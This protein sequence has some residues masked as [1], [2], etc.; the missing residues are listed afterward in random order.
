MNDQEEIDCSLEKLDRLKAQLS[1][2]DESIA[3]RGKIGYFPVGTALNSEPV[4]KRRK[5]SAVVVG[6]TI[7]LPLIARDR[8]AGSNTVFRSAL[9][10]IWSSDKAGQTLSRE[11]LACENG[12]SIL[13]SG[14]RL[15]QRDFLVMATVLQLV[16]EDLG[17]P[18]RTTA[19]QFLKSMGLNDGKSNYVSLIDSLTRLHEASVI[20]KHATGELALEGQLLTYETR[21]EKGIT[22]M[23]LS[24]NKGWASL[25]GV[26]SWTA[27]QQ[28]RLTRLG[29]KEFALWLAGVLVTHDGRRPIHID[30]LHL[31]SGL[32][33]DRRFFRRSVRGALVDCV[34]AGIIKMGQLTASDELVFAPNR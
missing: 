33:T 21:I 2:I 9:F 7:Q 30:K 22:Y 18:V 16:R 6:E 26:A 3:E 4:I 31:M 1:I 23:E 19:W 14:S 11:V 25:F 13:F 8:I 34:S 10:G 32:T 17:Q 24:A 5:R 20:I 27:V 12:A 29:K 15:W 28:M